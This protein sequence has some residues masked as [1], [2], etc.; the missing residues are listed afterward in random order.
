M[1]IFIQISKY[2]SIL[3]NYHRQE[4]YFYT[5]I[6]VPYPQNLSFIPRVYAWKDCATNGIELGKNLKTKFQIS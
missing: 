3:I 6:A 2:N 4:V 5:Q 1:R